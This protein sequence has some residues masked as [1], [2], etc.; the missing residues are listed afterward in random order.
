MTTREP[1]EVT[2]FFNQWSIYRSIIES[3]SME[4][5]EIYRALHDRLARRTQSFTVLDLGC[6][7]AEGIRPALQGTAA[8]RYIGVDRATRALEYAAVVLADLDAEVELREADL[9]DA[10]TTSEETFDV[11]VAAFALHHFGSDDKRRFLAAA[12]RRLRPGGELAL[13]D[14]VRR[15]G[16]SRAEYLDSYEL[17]VDGWSIPDEV[18]PEVIAH[19]RGH[20]YPEE[21]AKLP[22]WAH[23][24][25]FTVVEQ[26][27]AGG[28]GTQAAWSMLV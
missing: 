25:G 6:G 15:E 3:N 16:Q 26:W 21:I 2:A 5:V 23:E 27:Y 9:L 10:V 11:I 1:D 24:A 19:V 7:D 4:H 22:R 28:A 18:K 17:Y 8:A 14:V 12:R 13:I 20:D